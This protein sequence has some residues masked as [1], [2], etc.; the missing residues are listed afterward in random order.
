[1]R[2]KYCS[3]TEKIRFISQTSRRLLPGRLRHVCRLQLLAPCLF[4]VPFFTSH[5]SPRLAKLL[6]NV[7]SRW[8]G[9]F[10]PL[11][12]STNHSACSTLYFYGGRS[13][14]Q[15]M[16]PVVPST[17]HV[18]GHAVLAGQWSPAHGVGC[19]AGVSG[20][21]SACQARPGRARLTTPWSLQPAHG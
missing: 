5:K 13:S 8:F 10:R 12:G 3:L 17:M 6:G 7:H 9:W 20:A 14:M 21:S 19:H 1:M 4:H 11:I 2:K 16:E 18:T 15:C